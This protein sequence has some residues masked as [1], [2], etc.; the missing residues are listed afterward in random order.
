MSLP[1]NAGEVE[2][3]VANSFGAG[4]IGAI[5]TAMLYGLTTL[6][7]YLYFTN[8]PKDD[9]SV[10]TLVSVVWIIDSFHIALVTYCI[11]FY[12]VIN[13]SNPVG[14]GSIHWS[15][16]I[17]VFF[18]LLL[19]VLV[20]SFFTIQV[21]SISRGVIRWI[22]TTVL[23]ITVVAHFAFGLET[24]AFLF[25]SK[26]FTAFQ[27]SQTVKL[28]AATPFAIF[29]VLSDVLI[30]ASLCVLLHGNRTG[31]GKTNTLITTLIIYAVNRCL[32]TSAVAVTEV[33]VFA[34]HPTSL[35]FLAIDF[36]I[37]KLYANSLLA[38]LNSRQSLRE[39]S[40][41]A[42]TFSNF[43]TSSNAS[44]GLQG[45]GRHSNPERGGT[46]KIT[47]GH[48]GQEVPVALD[49]FNSHDRTAED[50]SM[51]SYPAPKI[52]TEVYTA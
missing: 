1:L 13:F 51:M 4:L 14:L 49:T 52:T 37:G 26:T 27:Q 16:N 46:R 6:Q 40:N 5:V 35:W 45:S 10:K 17:T 30:A 34:R 47:F 20:Q 32:L 39:R 42:S 22:L 41:E 21:Y 28:A 19:A 43:N 33:I 3:L 18:N 23:V 11:Y 29:A 12:L 9:L 48:P 24:V 50:G 36:V 2:S 44:S 8:Y 38:S 31:W 15:L 7:T 25:I